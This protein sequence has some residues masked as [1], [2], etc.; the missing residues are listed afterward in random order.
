MIIT[1]QHKLEY[2]QHILGQ[3]HHDST[4]KNNMFT[5]GDFSQQYRG[6]VYQQQKGM[7]S[8]RSGRCLMLSFGPVLI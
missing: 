3:N 7:P 2:D 8:P 6:D 5:N 1:K 4:N